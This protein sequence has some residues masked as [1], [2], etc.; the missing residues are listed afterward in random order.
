VNYEGLISKIKSVLSLFP[1]EDVIDV[2]RPVRYVDIKGILILTNRRAIFVQEAGVISKSYRA[3]FSVRLEDLAEKQIGLTTGDGSV[4]LGEFKVNSSNIGGLSKFYSDRIFPQAQKSK[5]LVEYKGDWM[6][7]EKKFEREQLDKGLVKIKGEW[8]TAEE[9]FRREQEQFEK[10]QRA[11]GL[12]KFM[13]RWGTPE[14]VEKWKKLYTGLTSDF[15]DRS[16]REFE[17]FISELFTKMG[18]STSLT[19]Q[20]KD[21]GADIVAKKDGETTVVQVKRYKLGNVVG[22]NDVNQVLGSMHLYDADRAVVVTTSNFT[23]DAKKLARTAPVELW[24]RAKLYKMIQH[25]FFG[26]SESKVLETE[27]S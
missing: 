18:Y 7:S 13:A 19:T 15:M 20:S 8:I 6:T 1:N 23:L 2:F 14:Q 4:E 12:V 3:A 24:N 9:Q 26:D 27:L 11:K 16:P 17:E 21:F 22:V 25:Y 5:G 10:D